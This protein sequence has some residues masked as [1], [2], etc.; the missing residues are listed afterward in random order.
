MCAC[1]SIEASSTELVPETSS[2]V[3]PPTT[4][5]WLL[6]RTAAIQL[7]REVPMWLMVSQASVDGLYMRMVEVDY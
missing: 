4:I 1:Y 2:P 7:L 3:Y 5:S 6:G